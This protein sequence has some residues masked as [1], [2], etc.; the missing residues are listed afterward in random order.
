MLVE[1]V[2]VTTLEGPDALE[3]TKDLLAEYGFEL[4]NELIQDRNGN[5]VHSLTMARGKKNPDRCRSVLDLPHQFQLEWDRG[6]VAVA[7]AITQPSW[8]TS[9]MAGRPLLVAKNNELQ[10]HQQA[11]LAHLARMVEARLST[12]DPAADHRSEYE[13]LIRDIERDDAKHKK[14]IWIAVAFALGMIILAII[15]GITLSH[16]R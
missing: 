4:Q 12:R 2:F 15:L 3:A 1:H 9:R 16:I 8:Q 5:P 7:A 13:K 11:I 14:R 6:R 10:V